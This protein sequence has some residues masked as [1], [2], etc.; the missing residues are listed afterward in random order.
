MADAHQFSQ[1]NIFSSSHNP[2]S[3]TPPVQPLR[4]YKRSSSIPESRGSLASELE[5]LDLHKFPVPGGGK[6][7]SQQRGNDSPAEHYVPGMMAEHHS[8][9]KEGEQ[10]EEQHPATVGVPYTQYPAD[11]GAPQPARHVSVMHADSYPTPPPF[12]QRDLGR[13][14]RLSGSQSQS[15]TPLAQ[16]QY[17]PQETPASQA[18]GSSEHYQ[19]QP[20]NPGEPNTNPFPQYHQQYWP[21]GTGPNRMPSTSTTMARRGSPPP[22]ETPATAITEFEQSPVAGALRTSPTAPRVNTALQHPSESHTPRR[23]WTPTE[24]PDSYP[25]G[26][27][28][29]WHGTGEHAHAQGGLAPPVQ[30]Q[31]RESHSDQAP[32]ALEE[33]FNRLNMSADPPPSYASLSQVPSGRRREEP[34]TT[35]QGYPDEKRTV[36]VGASAP[37]LPTNTHQ[38]HP[39]FHNDPPSAGEQIASPQG[40][41]RQGLQQDP[42]TQHFSPPPQGPGA[43]PPMPEGWMAHMDQSSGQYYYIHM[44]TAHTQWEP[45][46]TGTPPPGQHPEGVHSQAQ[47]PKG[48]PQE[49][50]HGP[51]SLTSSGNLNYANQPPLGSPG[52]PPGTPGFPPQSAGFPP[53]K[54]GF[55]P[56]ESVYSGSSATLI[57]SPAPSAMGIPTTPGF[58][59]PPGAAF[60][61]VSIPG[62]GIDQFPITPVN[63]E[64]FGPYLRYTNMNLERGIWLGSI[65]LVTEYGQAPTIHI[66]MS[67]DLSPNP[68]QLKGMPIYTHRSWTFFRYDIDLQMEEMPEMWTYAISTPLG[69]TRFEYLVAGRYERNWRFIGHSCNEFSLGVKPEERVKMGGHGFMWKDLMSKHLDCGGFHAQIGGGD[70]IYADRMWKELQPLKVPNPG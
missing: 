37:V 3:T 41:Q 52:F 22:P 27:P 44:A 34:R 68:R 62:A 21:P 48:H 50:H 47:G 66:H 32:E 53:G 4:I 15:P 33:D 28:T 29:V 7:N 13:P 63:G 26:P 67:R 56:P 58:G 17:Q 20:R 36:V 18:P 49:P 10:H 1:E 14:A 31:R 38:Q 16:T 25:H 40:P 45:P 59:P 35:A 69:C 55:P 64:Y 54:M 42:R 5:E 9:P 8:A 57:G 70:Q 46:V 23:P 11:N 39:A 12:R 19:Q 24:S 6:L 2:T 65:M 60:T 30:E 43:P 51:P 61:P